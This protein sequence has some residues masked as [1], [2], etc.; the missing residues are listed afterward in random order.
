[1]EKIG[2]MIRKW[3]YNEKGKPINPTKKNLKRQILTLHRKLKKGDKVF[4]EYSIER[5]KY[6][7]RNHIHIILHYSDKENL[8]NH[9]SKFI[10]EG[11][12]KK[13]E[14]GMN[15][16]DECNGKFGMIH[17]E[18]IEDEWRYRG[19]INKSELSTTLI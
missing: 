7:N 17:T 5:D 16:F 18:K 12:W 6:V 9:L 10:G 11:E 8:Y 2:V 14:N 1:M 4:T 19:Y 13:R 3:D 15:V